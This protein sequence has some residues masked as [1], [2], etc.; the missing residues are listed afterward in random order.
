VVEDAKAR[1][2]PIKTGRSHEDLIE[3]VEGHLRPGDR[4]VVTGNE[5]LQDQ[6]AVV[7]KPTLRN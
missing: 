4:V 7:T 2:V 6:M 1:L 5:M 3:V